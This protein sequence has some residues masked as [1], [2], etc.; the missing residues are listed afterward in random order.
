MTEHYDVIV[1][2]G[3]N[4][5]FS[6]AHAAREQ[7]ERVLL[8]EKASPAWAGGNSYFTA[9]AFRTT[10]ASL[11]ELLPVLDQVDE[12]RLQR[13]ELPPYTAEDF[14]RDMQ[15]ITQGCCDPE[16]AEILVKES[17]DTIRWLHGRGLRFQLL[18]ERQSF[19]VNGEFRFWGGL[20]LGTVGGGK[21]LMAQHLQAASASGIE[22]RYASPVVGLL[23]DA[24]G[25]VNGVTCKGA[26]GTYPI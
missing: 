1:V 26:D 6:A 25:T 19:N 11:D 13:T 20:S 16:L 12:E 23:C 4:A 9:G 7:V 8:L 24:N 2:G 10:F 22:V 15:R 3:G 17:G 5:G 21:G 14:M 18:Y